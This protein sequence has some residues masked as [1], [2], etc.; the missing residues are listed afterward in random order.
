[1]PIDPGR[2]LR[3]QGYRDPARIRPRIKAIAEQV[4]DRAASIIAPTIHYRLVPVLRLDGALLELPGEV[5]FENQAFARFLAGAEQV[6][7]FVMTMG[8]ALDQE[9]AAELDRDNLVAGLFLEMAGWLGIEWTTK[10]LA[11]HLGAWAREHGLRLTTRMGPGYRYKL[12]GM[13]VA[14]PLDQQERLFALFDDVPLPV[15]LLESSVMLPKMSRS[16][17]YGL[18]PA[19]PA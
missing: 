1:M 13:E 7:V 2:I 14:W 3:L 4:A 9:V 16:G 8:P 10:Q 11:A 5:R 15:R 17:L 18:V 12:H 6:A 19:D